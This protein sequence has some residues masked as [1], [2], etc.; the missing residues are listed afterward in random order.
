MLFFLGFYKQPFKITHKKIRLKTS[1]KFINMKNI[2]LFVSFLFLISCQ[3]EKK[4][5]APVTKDEKIK[6]EIIPIPKKEI[7]IKEET[8]NIYPW[9]K[10]YDIKKSIINN[11]P[12]PEGYQRIP[13]ESGSFADWLRHLPLKEKGS[14][15]HYHNGRTKPIHVHHA[16]LDIDTGKEDLQQCADAVMRLKSEYH[17]SLKE[18]ESIHF[19]YTSGDNVSF[20]D[21]RKGKKPIVRGNR[22]DFSAPSGQ[23]DNSY[24][25]FKKYIQQIFTYAGTA[26]LSREMNQVIRINDIEVGDVFIIGGHPG[27]AVIVIDVAENDRKEKIFMIAQSYMPAQDIHILKNP[28]DSNMSPWYSIDFGEKLFTP[29]WTFDASDLKRF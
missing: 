1:N 16:V 14:R 22:V 6:K 11:I 27:H 23:T 28:N 20:D 19:N 12:L 24:S 29:E 4:E 3:K 9:K 5:T 13:Y 17:Y 26:S 15:V 8:K 7:K 25:N 18:F 2:F 21:W 10:D